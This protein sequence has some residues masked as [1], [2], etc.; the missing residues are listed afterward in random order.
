MVQNDSPGHVLN[1]FLAGGLS[2]RNAAVRRSTALN[3]EK[4]AH[5][6]GPSRLLNSK[7]Q[8]LTCSFL[9]AVSKLAL[10]SAQEVRFHSRNTLCEIHFWP[11]MKLV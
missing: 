10:D 8:S 3:L 2:H 9:T 11:H 4:L 5:M 6:L 1:A 7:K